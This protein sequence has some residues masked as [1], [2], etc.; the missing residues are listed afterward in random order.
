MSLEGFIDTASKLVDR[1][2]C[3]ANG[4]LDDQ[5]LELLERWLAC[6]FYASINPNILQSKSIGGASKSYQVGQV[7]TGIEGTPYG[8]QALALDTTGC[9]ESITGEKV[10]LTWVGDDEEFYNARFNEG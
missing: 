3:C 2:E 10:N 5:T 7:G 4:K 1:V 9:L 8:Q 6:H